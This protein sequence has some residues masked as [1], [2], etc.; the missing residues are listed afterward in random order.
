M[1]VEEK[2]AGGSILLLD[3][4][5]KYLPDGKKVEYTPTMMIT[6]GRNRVRVGRS[7][8]KK[9]ADIMERSDLQEWL[10]TLPE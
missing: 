1:A 3:G 10:K 8:L 4:S 2:F 9:L 7:F 6:V 5:V